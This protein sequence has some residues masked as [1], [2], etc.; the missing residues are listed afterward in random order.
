MSSD[1]TDAGPKVPLA[2][3]KTRPLERNLALTRLGLGAGA[4]IAAHS[5]GNLFRSAQGREQADRSFYRRQAEELALQLGQLKG[6]VMK[7]GQMLSLYGQYFLPADAVAALAQLQDDTTPVEWA[8][9]LPVLQNGLGARLDALDID[10]QPMAAASLG[11]VHRAWRRADGRALCV[12]LQYPGV[13]QAIDSDIRT[14]SRLFALSRLAP[15][16]LDLGPMFDELREML[17]AEVDYAGEASY[18]RE[19]G[20]RLDGDARYVVPEV[21]DDF[22]TDR[23]LTTS[24]ETGF[25]VRDAAVQGLPQ[26]RRD[27]LGHRFFALF[28]REFF[29]WG[30]VQTDPHFGN[31]RVRLGDDASGDQLVLLDFGA[32]RRYDRAFI[33][34]YAD[35]V[36][37][38]VLRDRERLLAGAFAI[39]VMRSSYPSAVLQGFCE[40]SETI[41]E[42][43][44]DP[45]RADVDRRHFD[46]RGRYHFAG[47]DL[48]ARAS[49]IAARNSLTLHFKLPPRE[50]VFLHRRLLGVL[51]ALSALR[52]ELS[53]RDVL[54]QALHQRPAG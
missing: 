15:R 53:L 27:A 17:H 14:L 16:G 31:Y 51:V 1:P 52:S 22:S 26:A 9:L 18:T 8:L 33:D 2:A 29:D 20:Q 36:L 39:D 38:A 10:P 13:A 43:F 19:F 28:L 40:M 24:F 41:V 45:A 47:T 23:I 34:G 50:I 25:N 12:K 3:L 4:Q 54:L 21:F 49:Q 6:S 11:Q 48:V 7:A 46:A 30:L 5:V 32:S 37:G 42:P 44:S 35:I